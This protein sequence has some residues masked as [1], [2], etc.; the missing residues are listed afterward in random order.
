M[1]DMEREIATQREKCMATLENLRTDCFARGI[2]FQM[3]DE[4]LPKGQAYYQYPDGHVE[5]RQLITG[6]GESYTEHIRNLTKQ[7]GAQILLD[8]GLQ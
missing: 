3:L 7:E 5:I 1:S 8:H 2:P 6:K 4:K